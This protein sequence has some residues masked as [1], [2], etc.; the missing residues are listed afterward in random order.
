MA[1]RL[2]SEDRPLRV[3]VV[4]AGPSGFYVAGA[5]LGHKEIHVEVDLF[6]RL[7]TPF[8][9]VRYG[10]APDHQSIKNVARVYE[11][12]AMEPGFRFFGHVTIGEDLSIDELRK[13]YDQIVLT[14]G[15]ESDRKL[16]I[17]GE[18]LEG[19]Y[20]ATE[21]VAWYNGHPDSVDRHFDL[22][23]E[24]VAVIGVGNV[25]IDVA[26]ILARSIEELRKTDIADHALEAL[27]Q[28]NVKDIY[29]I[30]RRGPAQAK[31]TP[32]EIREF[33][34]L[35]EADIILEAEALDLDPISEDAVSS[36]GYAQKNLKALRLLAESDVSGKPKRVHLR[37]LRSPVKLVSDGT[38]RVDAIRLE[39]NRLEKASSGYIQAV[40]TGSYETIPVGLVFRSVGYHG[41]PIEGI[42]FNER[43]GIIPNARG[44]V[45]DPESGQAV[46]GL[47]VAGWI[48][49]GPTGIVGTNKPCAI[50]TV[51]HMIADLSNTEAVAE[52]NAAADAVVALLRSKNIRFVTFDDWIR[53]DALEKER[54]AVRGAPRSK[55]VSVDE[56]LNALA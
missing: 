5:L 32:P 54:G 4:G 14:V 49:R 27:S 46:P 34:R 12:T 8:G 9:L 22:S 42:P 17:P 37:F 33:S 11:K 44:L 50:E 29:V 16:G 28:S 15:A 45:F 3:A 21:F 24:N 1:A 38:G 23:C 51:D 41:V 31:F 36:N 19:S 10:V 43:R 40:G 56:M 39:K 47:Y 18:D 48:K 30:G 26:R 2:G 20:S 35:Q 13:Y 6:D 53:I 52:E 7:P 55:F 25:A